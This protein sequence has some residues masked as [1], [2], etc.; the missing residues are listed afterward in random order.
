MEGDK[1]GRELGFPTANIKLEDESKLLPALG[2]YAVEII[3][4][5]NKYFGLLS[6]GKR[7][8][9]YEDGK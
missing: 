1:R 5:N 2:V 8:T 3:V 9:F 6:V 4:D 7:P